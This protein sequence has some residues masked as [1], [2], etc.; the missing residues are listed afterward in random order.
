MRNTGQQASEKSRLQTLSAVLRD[1]RHSALICLSQTSLG[2]LGLPLGCSPLSPGAMPSLSE[3]NLNEAKVAHIFC[4]SPTW[5][6]PGPCGQHFLLMAE[7][8][9]RRSQPRVGVLW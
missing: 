5:L 2:Y 8:R 6:A 7:A 9:L 3:V 4:I 1:K